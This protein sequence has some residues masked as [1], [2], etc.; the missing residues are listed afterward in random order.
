M[1]WRSAI[2]LIVLSLLSRAVIAQFAPTP[3]DARS[4][5]MGGCFMADADR[6]SVDISYRQGFALAGMADKRLSLLWPT[7]EAGL[8]TATYMH[9]GNL[10]YHE[11]Q[12][13]FG[14]ALCPMEWLLVGVGG[15]WL[16]VG[17]S[18]PYY[19]PQHWLA[20]TA[21]MQA[22]LSRTRL[23]MLVGTRPWDAKRLYRLHMQAQYAVRNNLLTVVELE[24]EECA[25][26]RMGME[27]DFEN[28]LFFRAGIS[29]APLVATFG[30]GI[31]HHYFN[32]DLGA[33]THQTLGVTP[34]TS[35]K[36]CF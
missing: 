22:S 34:H 5:A 18:D 24:L 16:N 1:R 6:R 29:T 7:G 17:T 13:A 10:D 20:A 35:I 9:H 19:T 27:Y 33:E 21:Y 2:L 15:K 25:R 23:A 28:R 3:L 30:L 11:Q 32:I 31:R 12:A 14:Y 26:M 4:G 36:I 8:A